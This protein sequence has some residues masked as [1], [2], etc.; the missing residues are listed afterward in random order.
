[1]L[2]TV[3]QKSWELAPHLPNVCWAR[4]T[5]PNYN[6]TS[7]AAAV[8]REFGVLDI[9]GSS[10]PA[11][12]F[13][14]IYDGAFWRGDSPAQSFTRL[15]LTGTFPIFSAGRFARAR[16]VNFPPLPLHSGPWYVQRDQDVLA[17]LLSS[18]APGT[19]PESGGNDANTDDL[20]RSRRR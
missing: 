1:M 10:P 3:P 13:A 9:D 11:L 7:R 8:A 15:P 18:P 17:R 5:L 2:R 14:D 20:P 6:A 4:L 19:T 16:T 12:P